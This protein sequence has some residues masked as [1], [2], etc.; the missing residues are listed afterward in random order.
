MR[1]LDQCRATGFLNCPISGYKLARGCNLVLCDIEEVFKKQKCAD[2]SIHYGNDNYSV[3]IGLSFGLALAL[4]AILIC[5]F[6]L[7]PQCKKY[8]FKKYMDNPTSDSQTLLPATPIELAPEVI[9]IEPEI[10]NNETK[11]STDE[12]YISKFVYPGKIVQMIT[13]I[14]RT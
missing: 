1:D 14:P 5:L 3:T 7:Y 12:N 4:I 11:N 6:F 13:P 2:L 10:Q 8:F 9:T